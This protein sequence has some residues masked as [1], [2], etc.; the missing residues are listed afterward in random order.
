MCS[1]CDVMWCHVMWS[2]VKWCHVMSC[3]VMWCHVMS[4]YHVMWWCDVIWC[5]VMTWVSWC[6]VVS[7]DVIWCHVMWSYVE[8]CHVMSCDDMWLFSRYNA[9][10]WRRYAESR[11]SSRELPCSKSLSRLLN[12]KSAM[13]GTTRAN[14]STN[15]SP[16]TP[17]PLSPPPHTHTHPPLSPPSTVVRTFVTW[18]HFLRSSLDS[19]M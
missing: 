11:T 5:H 3:D 10:W 18:T 17:P 15:I 4:W 19:G 1:G 2:Y 14:Y 16:H 6:H 13:V 8:W 9:G 7:C 12:S